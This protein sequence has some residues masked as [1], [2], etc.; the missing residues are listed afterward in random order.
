[1]RDRFDEYKE[2]M[3]RIRLT[4]SGKRT[5]V[6]A[7]TEREPEQKTVR[8]VRPLRVALIAACV[9]LVLAGTAFA[10][11]WARQQ[12]KLVTGDELTTW[13]DEEGRE[14]FTWGSND[15][16]NGDPVEIRDGRM[17][18]VADGKELDITDLV[19]EDTPYIYT[20]TLSDG[21]TS[22]VIVGGTPEDYGFLECVLHLD[23]TPLGL[24]GTGFW[25]EEVV[26]EGVEE[27]ADY[28]APGIE[29]YVVTGRETITHYASWYVA[30][31]EQLGFSEFLR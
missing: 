29:L 17:W 12:A 15:F 14:M 24:S 28:A 9:C 18:F 31:A 30:A 10:A 27:P 21:H 3:D 22:Y 4:D 20:S 26:K 25:W 16:T 2:Q 1:M 13:F 23:G 8:I 6:K 5:L 7:L 11:E 19:D